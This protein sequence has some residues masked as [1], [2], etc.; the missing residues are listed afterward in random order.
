MFKKIF[1]S[2]KAKKEKI[3]PLWVINNFRKLKLNLL[4]FFC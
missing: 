3:I 2:Q 4:V 1:I